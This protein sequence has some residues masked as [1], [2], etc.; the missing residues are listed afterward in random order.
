MKKNKQ[1]KH[2]LLKRAFATPVYAAGTIVVLLAVFGAIAYVAW[3][4]IWSFGYQYHQAYKIASAEPIKSLILN[5]ID[6]LG[7]DA[8]VEET[9]GDVYFPAAKVYLPQPTDNT[10]LGYARN[11]TEDPR[12]FSIYDRLIINVAKN[13]MLQAE[14]FDKAFAAVPKL[15]ACSRGVLIRFSQQ[16]D[17]GFE[18]QSATETL[19]LADGRLLYAS[20]DTGCS[21]NAD[22]LERLR[23]LR[24]Y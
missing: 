20:Y 14:D 6:S 15:Q 21:A 12:D 24:S 22:L 9:T 10:R 8:P 19:R 2:S 13:D 1:Q 18:S 23:S 4:Y 5:S 16:T 7:Q 11:A 3:G 17:S